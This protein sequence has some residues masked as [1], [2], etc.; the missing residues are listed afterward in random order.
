MTK[1]DWTFVAHDNG[2]GHQVLKIKA[3]SKD[4]AIRKGFEKANA[5]AKGDIFKWDCRL[6]IKV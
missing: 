2:G 1:F 3:T 6:N 4:E 5:K